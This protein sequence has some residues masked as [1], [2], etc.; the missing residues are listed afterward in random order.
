M[1][2]MGPC[3]SGCSGAFQTEPLVEY[4]TELT[5]RALSPVAGPTAACGHLRRRGPRTI[6]TCASNRRRQTAHRTCRCVPPPWA[7]LTVVSLEQP[8][9]VRILV[10]SVDQRAWRGAAAVRIL[11]CQNRRRIRPSM[12]ACSVTWLGKRQRAIAV[13][14][15]IRRAAYI[16]DAAGRYISKPLTTCWRGGRIPARLSSSTCCTNS[17]TAAVRPA[18]QSI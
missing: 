13:G 14:L 9:T 12:N 11:R 18:S 6:S 1:H 17:T 7:P 5:I 4:S 2:C 16:A 10:S 8:A 3:L 15:G